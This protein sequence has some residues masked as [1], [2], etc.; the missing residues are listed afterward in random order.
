M[1]MRVRQENL[2]F[3]ELVKTL[4]KDIDSYKNKIAKM[5]DDS[6]DLEFLKI[7]ECVQREELA[8]LKVEHEKLV[9]TNRINE[10]RVE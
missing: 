8:K 10:E 6:R 1:N 9:E 7:N 4:E 3:R 5:K 2:Q